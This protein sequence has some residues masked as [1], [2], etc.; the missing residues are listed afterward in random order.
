MIAFAHFH[1][2]WYLF[3]GLVEPQLSVV[4]HLR[5]H[6]NAGEFLDE[7]A[8]RLGF[9]F[10][11]AAVATATAATEDILNRLKSFVSWTQEGERKLISVVLKLKRV[12]RE[13]RLR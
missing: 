4:L 9:L 8:V 7:G 13:Q 2:L 6:R 3:D 12:R 5:P 11:A 1:S 10:F